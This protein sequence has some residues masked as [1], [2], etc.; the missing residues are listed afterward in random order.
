MKALV[1]MMAIRRGKV[2]ANVVGMDTVTVRRGAIKDL[3]RTSGDR[4]THSSRPT[5]ALVRTL[6]APLDTRSCVSGR[7]SA[8]FHG[9]P[10]GSR[11]DVVAVR[12]AMA[13]LAPSFACA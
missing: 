7:I 10:R 4:Y 2:D 5:C 1:A 6:R 3:A 13:F 9:S 8:G 12:K 11:F